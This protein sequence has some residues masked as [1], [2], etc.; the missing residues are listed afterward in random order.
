MPRAEI[1]REGLKKLSLL[2]ILGLYV[3]LFPLSRAVGDDRN[4]ALP[5]TD[6]SANGTSEPG[7]PAARN[8][9]FFSPEDG[10]FDISAFLSERYGFI[11]M[12]LIITEPAVGFG[13]G[14]NLMFLHDSL[15]S[16]IERKSPPS[17]SG[18]ALAATENGT[19]A[20]AAYH[21]G[22]W[23]QDTIRTTSAAGATDLNMDFYLRDRA[24]N[25]NYKVWFA[26]QEIMFRLGQ[27]PFFAGSNFVFA[28]IKSER[29]NRYRPETG[30]FFDL[31]FKLGALGVFFQYDSR[32]SIF[33]PSSGLF[34]KFTGRRFDD[35]FGGNQN[36]W[37]YGGK[38]FCYFP[39]SPKVNIGIRMEGEAVSGSRVPFFANPYVMLRGIPAM[40][41]QGANMIL[42]ET[43]LRWEFVPR[44]N[45]VLFI[46]GGKVY[47]KR[48]RFERGNGIVQYSESLAD[49]TLHPAGGGGFRYELARK[50]GLWAGLDFAT[51]D[52]ED[53]SFYIT[54]GS[55]WHAF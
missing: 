36:F 38:M 28:D 25:L 24:V 51:S 27:S 29:N 45:L 1:K 54:V 21:A 16:S 19:L 46:G 12:P 41:Y 30:N 14:L 35:A 8:P 50:Y 6:V 4:I 48:Y 18:A 10:Q 34:V 31:R 11:P 9:L 32:D 17:I 22:F 20:G 3:T 44:W 2:V 49:A 15:G 47:G 7:G 52:A 40:R 33:T 55:A 26:Y 53:F 23:R 39:V 42:G 43:E 37:R 5:P 13:G